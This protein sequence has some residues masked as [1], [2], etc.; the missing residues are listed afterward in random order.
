ML[1]LSHLI[2]VILVSWA[3]FHQ[4]IFDV[5]P[6]LEQ[7]LVSLIRARNFAGKVLD[8]R[9]K[10]GEEGRSRSSDNIDEI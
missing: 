6:L 9:V 7:E 8:S 1:L 2:T 5:R 4:Y 3:P 10:A